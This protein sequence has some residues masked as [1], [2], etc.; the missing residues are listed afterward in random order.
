MLASIERDASLYEKIDDTD[1]EVDYENSD[2][3]SD[4]D[5]EADMDVDVGAKDIGVEAKDQENEA[6]CGVYFDFA[7]YYSDDLGSANDPVDDTTTG[8][9]S[10]NEQAAK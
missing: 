5:M 4:V 1:M 3:D 7:A 2:D 6:G 9:A 10:M 8:G